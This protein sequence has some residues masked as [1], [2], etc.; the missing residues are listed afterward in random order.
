MKDSLVQIPELIGGWVLTYWLHSTLLLGLLAIG[1]LIRDRLS[2]TSASGSH[3]FR[4]RVWK[5]AAIAGVVTASLQTWLGTGFR[6]DVPQAVRP[7]QNSL[8][9]DATEPADSTATTD[10]LERLSRL[11]NEIPDLAVDDLQPLALAGPAQPVPLLE[12]IAASESELPMTIEVESQQTTAIAPS[13][14]SPEIVAEVQISEPETLPQLSAPD[15]SPVDRAATFPS[16]RT[17]VGW[18]M[19]VWAASSVLFLVVQSLLFRRR[20]RDAG[21]GSWTVI[22]QLESAR[23]RL[24]VSRRIELLAS[25]RVTEPVA[26]GL[27]GWRIAIPESL[28]DDISTEE[29][30]ALFAHE[31]AHLQRGDVVW[32][33]VGRLLTTCFAI[34][35]LNFLA[36]REWQLHAEFQCDDWAVAKSVDAVCLARSLTA[37]AE[38]RTEAS[39]VA[40]ALPAGGRRSHITERVERLLTGPGRDFWSGRLP[41]L[42]LS[43]A[44]VSVVAVLTMHGPAAGVAASDKTDREI[45]ALTNTVSDEDEAEN[46]I[47]LM[48]L[49]T[50]VGGLHED[51]DLLG[52]ELDE[53]QPLLKRLPVDSELRQQAERIQER[54]QKLSSTTGH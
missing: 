5:F 38:L 35:P 26:F 7:E 20:M 51:L 49:G 43:A 9:T 8:T 15:V 14:G 13:A 37:V 21:P 6:F 53:L 2:R 23:N 31:I 11:L 29:L 24:G 12:A 1:L 22:Q 28:E 16:L 19:V 17:V 47:L 3:A 32:L 39:V 45:S 40:A 44:A 10:G 48:Q 41:R 18:M 34:Q 33:L 25:G 50:E 30:D 4:E 52:T 46:Q 42:L 36:K 54:L 27:F